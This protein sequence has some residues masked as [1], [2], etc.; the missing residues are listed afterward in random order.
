MQ[1]RSD[2]SSPQ[3]Y[4]NQ[5][6]F[7]SIMAD[8]AL[9]FFLEYFPDLKKKGV[10]SIPGQHWHPRLQGREGHPGSLSLLMGSVKSRVSCPVQGGIFCS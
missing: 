8:D 6:K 3:A 9:N 2:H 4:V 1:C 10:D 5:F 7:Q